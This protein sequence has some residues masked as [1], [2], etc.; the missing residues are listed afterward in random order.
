[1]KNA[2]KW[3]LSLFRIMSKALCPKEIEK[4]VTLGKVL[5]RVRESK[6][7]LEYI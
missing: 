2:K 6:L 3:I 1:M 5:D 4:V 7:S